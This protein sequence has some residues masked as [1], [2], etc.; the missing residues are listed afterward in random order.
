MPDKYDLGRL[1]KVDLRSIWTSEASDFTPWLA[2]DENIE[3]LSSAIGIEL[4]VESVE[5]RVGPF[6]ADILCKN[7]LDD[8]WVL[9]ENQ[10]ERTD[11]S[12]L[13]QLLTYAAGLKAQTIVWIAARFT[14][15]HRA[16]LDWLNEFTSENLGFFGIEVELWR[17]G[18]SVAAPRFNVL[19]SPN[20]WS[21][22]VQEQKERLDAGPMTPAGQQYFD[23][24]TSFAA[25][26]NDTGRLSPPKPHA[27]SWKTFST[28][29]SGV[30]F[31]ATLNA[32]ASTIRFM[33][34]LTNQYAKTYFQQ[35]LDRRAE[36]EGI[37]GKTGD[38]LKK[39]DH[40]QSQV[41]IDERAVDLNAPATWSA[42]HDWIADWLETGKA[43]RP[44]FATLDGT[45]SIGIASGTDDVEDREV[46]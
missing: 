33:L 30:H 12:H 23:F 8:S 46:S 17:I 29:R 11:H 44:I 40:K 10:L 27:D 13:G 32:R 41:I 6:R 22:S 34:E 15:E 4:E 25:R 16:A 19:S 43:L 21:K 35:L 7:T 31:V 14:E 3:L 45:L 39:P 36:V 9:I 42:V 28:G 20:A 37:L 38:W 24:W 18:S 26:M 1:E 5:E 2:R